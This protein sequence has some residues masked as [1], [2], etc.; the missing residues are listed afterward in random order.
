MPAL[1]GK[2]REGRKPHGIAMLHPPVDSI[3]LK[4]LAQKN[5]GGLGQAYRA[6]ASQRWSN[7]DS[8]SYEVL[9]VCIR[10]SFQPAWVSVKLRQIK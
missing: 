1:A 10:N 5:S 4:A 9:I 6:A 7:L 2:C 3:L 8:E